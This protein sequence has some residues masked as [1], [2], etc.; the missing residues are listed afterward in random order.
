MLLDSD[1]FSEFRILVMLAKVSAT[2]YLFS[3]WFEFI[4]KLWR[5]WVIIKYFI[6]KSVICC[7]RRKTLPVLMPS[8]TGSTRN[9]SICV[10]QTWPNLKGEKRKGASSR[11]KRERMLNSTNWLS[12]PS[13]ELK[14]NGWLSR[15]KTGA[16]QISWDE[17]SS[18]SKKERSGETR[19]LIR[20]WIQR[21][22]S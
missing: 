11:K 19:G 3:D 18:S 22:R 20:N 9:Q 6:Q 7:L 4:W 8:H 5:D 10:L 14:P 1:C 21:H 12:S 2:L 15:G 17:R 13:L 16:I